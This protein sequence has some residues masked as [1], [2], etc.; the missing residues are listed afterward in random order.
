MFLGRD[1]CVDN[2]Y[3]ITYRAG[4]GKA[5]GAVYGARDAR[6]RAAP[7]VA[8]KFPV[9]EEEL[10][11]IKALCNEQGL[12]R[13][14]GVP[15]ILGTGFHGQGPFV[16]MEMLGKPLSDLFKRLTSTVDIK[17]RALCALGR[18]LLR[19]L[20]GVHSCGFVHCDVQPGN[21]LFGR[22]DSAG[23]DL[24][25]Q[26]AEQHRPFLVD[27]GCAQR[28]PGGVAK[29]ADF[30]SVDFNSIR[31]AEGG[32]RH[33]FDDLESL[34]WVLCHGLFGELPWFEFTKSADWVNGKLGDRDRPLVCGQVQRAKA[35]LIDEGW[36]SF[37]AEF[38]RLEEMPPDLLEF[39][40]V[41]RQQGA[42]AGGSTSALP[43]YGALALLLGGR[44]TSPEEAEEEDLALYLRCAEAATRAAPI[45]AVARPPR[46][47]R[48]ASG[49]E[50]D[51]HAVDGQAASGQAAAEGSTPDVAVEPTQEAPGSDVAA[52]ERGGKREQAE[53]LLERW[54]AHA[55]QRAQKSQTQQVA[56]P[57]APSPN[58]RSNASEASE[59]SDSC[60]SASGMWVYNQGRSAYYVSRQLDGSALY[61]QPLAT[62]TVLW[63]ELQTLWGPPITDESSDAPWTWEAELNNGGRIRLRRD[64]K[65]MMTSY[66]KSGSDVWCP[67]RHAM[68]VHR[69]KEAQLHLHGV[70]SSLQVHS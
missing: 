11:A 29:R 63:G 67:P 6:D 48:A 10:E 21:I 27:F 26:I 35:T 30:G 3:I 36:S 20:Q 8:V 17:W 31:S 25:M 15:R 2:R 42:S 53:D 41:C 12:P 7:S 16:V 32:T 54:R 66:L 70:T 33:P 60:E 50:P 45:S 4:Q 46:L 13:C 49:T 14:L 22:G 28:F 56:E 69:E 39:L 43:D 59:A 9:R 62:G 34:G 19:R 23:G 65:L 47:A 52:A 37:G 57:R 51:G 5:G 44:D 58:G 24:A 61:E 38:R 18:L 40:R 55:D 64:G 1:T 68:R